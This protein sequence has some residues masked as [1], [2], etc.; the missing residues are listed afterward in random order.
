MSKDWASEEQCRQNRK[1]AKWINNA[2][3]ERFL[4][5]EDEQ[6]EGS[7]RVIHCPSER[8]QGKASSIFPVEPVL[9][10]RGIIM[11]IIVPVAKVAMVGTV[12]S[13]TLETFVVSPRVLV[14]QPAMIPLVRIAFIAVRMR[15][16]VLMQKLI[17]CTSSVILIVI[18]S[19]GRNDGGTQ[20][21][22]HGC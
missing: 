8:D 4:S 10:T 6:I 11:S 7:Q 15:Y 13:A 16:A 14:W 17:H 3:H 18:M 20:H 2:H 21:K 19:E 22:D 5:K 12:F 9:T 1:G